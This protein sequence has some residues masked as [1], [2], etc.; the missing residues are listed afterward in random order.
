MYHCVSSLRL[1]QK[2]QKQQQK[3]E[4]SYRPIQ[5]YA[6]MAYIPLFLYFI[7]SLLFL[8]FLL[9]K[10][11]QTIALLDF[12]ATTRHINFDN[13]NNKLY[14]AKS[15]HFRRQK[16]GKVGLLLLKTTISTTTARLNSGVVCTLK[17]PCE[18]SLAEP[19]STKIKGCYRSSARE[20]QRP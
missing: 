13:E 4:N 2:Q 7:I 5:L 14:C 17:R 19:L 18:V 20:R 8:L 6:Y 1:E 9:L 12:Y 15:L 10:S 11:I 3:T 16:C